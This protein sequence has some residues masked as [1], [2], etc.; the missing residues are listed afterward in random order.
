MSLETLR[1]RAV[2]ALKVLETA[3]AVSTPAALKV[4]PVCNAL[5]AVRDLLHCYGDENLIVPSPVDK[6][7]VAILRVFSEELPQLVMALEIVSARSESL[8]KLRATDESG[9]G[10]GMSPQVGK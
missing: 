7:S 6:D 9:R 5:L 4:D 8:L 10:K 3:K 2:D 1:R